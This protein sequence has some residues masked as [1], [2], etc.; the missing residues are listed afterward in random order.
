MYLVLFVAT[1]VSLRIHVCGGCFVKSS[2]MLISFSLDDF[3]EQIK[4]FFLGMEINCSCVLLCFPRVNERCYTVAC[5][6][7]GSQLLLPKLATN[8]SNRKFALTAISF[9][10]LPNHRYFPHQQDKPIPNDHSV[11]FRN[12]SGFMDVKLYFS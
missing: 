10:S 7:P 11:L 8:Y 5:T 6:R 4:V 12:P 3:R 2:R 1:Q 9:L